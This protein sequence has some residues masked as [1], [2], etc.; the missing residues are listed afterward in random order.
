MYNRAINQ[1][2]RLFSQDD[3]GNKKPTHCLIP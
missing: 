3:I 1:G 2:V